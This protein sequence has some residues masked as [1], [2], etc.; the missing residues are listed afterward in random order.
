MKK[1][2]CISILLCSVISIVYAATNN[3][4][5]ITEPS[6]MHEMRA[7][8]YPIDKS[9]LTKNPVALMWPLPYENIRNTLDGFRVD[10]KK[11]S[12][13]YKIRLS[14]DPQLKKNVIETDSPWPFYNHGKAFGMG[15][16]YW[17]YAYTDNSGKYV[18]S[19]IYTFT[20]NKNAAT[21]APPPA[22]LVLNAIPA[23]HPRV[24]LDG[25]SWDTFIAKCEKT[26]QRDW[27]LKR[28]DGALGSKIS[29]INDI[30]TSKLQ[31][32]TNAV[33]RNAL[34]T[35][36]SRRIVDREEVNIEALTR[37]YLL[38]KDPKYAKG[39][40]DRI[41]KI[42][43]W[44]DSPLVVGD[45]NSSVILS[46]STLAYDAFY[47]L[48]TE[49]QKQILLEQIRT[50]GGAMYREYSN[51]LELHIADNHVWQMTLRILTMAA[52]TTYGE[53]PEAS[54]WASYCY[55]V[56]VAR[57]PGLNEDG[58]WHNGDSYFGVNLR[59]LV[60]VPYLYSR[61]SG[62]DFFSDP[63]YQGNIMYVIY[64]F[65]PS[66]KSG[67]NGS[68]HQKVLS[69]DGTRM[70]YAE[71]LAR[72]TGSSYAG[73]Y[74]RHIAAQN[75]KLRRSALLAKAGDL[76]W[77][78]LQ[79]D[80]PL[81][82][83]KLSELPLAYVFPQS[84]LAFFD[85][86]LDDYSRNAMLSFR[87]SPYGSTSHALANQN[88]F[89]TFYGGKSLFY[90]SGHHISFVD[91]HSIY[92]HRG[93]RA[94]NTILVNGMGQR[95]G[96]EGFAWI[97]RYY[98]GQN[99][100]YVLGDASNAYGEVTSELWLERARLADV[101]LSPKTGWDK[102]HLKLFR[103]HVVEL[104]NAGL[105][106]IYDELEADS[107]VKFSYLLHTVEQAMQI[108]SQGGNMAHIKA[109]N[110]ANGTSDA[111]IFSTGKT[112]AMQTDTFFY[113]AD[114]WLRADDKGNFEPFKN[115]W[116]VTVETAPAKVYRF[117]TII[118]TRNSS[119]QG[120]TP[121]Q[122]KDGTIS[123]GEWE[124]KCN[125]SGSGK[126][127]LFIKNK[128]GDVQLNYN[129]KTMIKDGKTSVELTDKVPQLEI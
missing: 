13:S 102:N 33:Q 125:L 119:E 113:P 2:F 86:D 24:L 111:Y 96:V 51:H 69:P 65:M 54:L 19:K 20:V 5:I 25:K 120:V 27:Y 48:L 97:P 4:I 87:S 70:L 28:A 15:S 16:W 71:A 39:A 100:S 118:N 88:A 41:E 89:N 30:D 14:Q 29:S 62:F 73:D 36:E 77:T 26:P 108:I 83:G 1:I 107:A 101:E 95:I 55:N 105:M 123:V 110:S 49:A 94:H 6:L 91:K 42:I 121:V 23:Y 58:A 61:L 17:Q 63:W 44:N 67:G 68:S 75:P 10:K 43:S 40:L 127:A 11:V 8:E 37:S 112:S 7:T 50:T 66:S 22:N 104:G 74:V 82:R 93:T 106:L 116:H 115:H 76:T 59:T 18:W 72:L 117:L 32:L 114:N 12:I 53:L 21:F 90:S 92:C 47:N 64:N 31:G 34:L 84:G 122:R 57:F 52:F 126:S 99:I 46:I 128:K 103:R 45:F 98:S 38:T 109:T 60:E 80:K 79:I 78:L 124:V 35:R 85:S 129:E 9:T 81:P 56:W 3:R